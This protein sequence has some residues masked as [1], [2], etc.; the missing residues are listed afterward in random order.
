MAD[1]MKLVV[2]EN[3]SCLIKTTSSFCYSYLIFYSY[4]QQWTSGSC[5]TCFYRV[6]AFCY[7]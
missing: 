1:K 5:E 2:D 3:H 6:D 7:I 4:S